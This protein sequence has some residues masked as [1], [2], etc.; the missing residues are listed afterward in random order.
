MESTHV[1]DPPHPEFGGGEASSLL[2]WVADH[3]GIDRFAD[4][5]G[6]RC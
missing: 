4:P 1:S 5:S 3:H 6:R 2:M